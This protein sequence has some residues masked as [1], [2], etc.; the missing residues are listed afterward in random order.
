[1]REPAPAAPGIEVTRDP[2]PP[3]ADVV[4][5]WRRELLGWAVALEEMA[6]AIRQVATQ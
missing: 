5:D 6:A 3:A 2:A 4:T 1:M